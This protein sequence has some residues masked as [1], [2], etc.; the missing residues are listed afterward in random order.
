M[1]EKKYNAI[2]IAAVMLLGAFVSFLNSTFMNV[3]IPDIM[4]ELHITVSTAQ[5]LTNGYMLVLGIMIPFTAFL[6]DKFKTRTLFLAAMIIFSIG[7]LLGATA[8]SFPTLLTARL[9]QAAG[10][11]VLMPL[12]Q[13]VFLLIFPIEKRGL[14][15][16]VVG[17]IIAFAPAIGPTLSGWIVSHFPWRYL[18]YVTLPIALID[19]VLAIFILKNVTGGKK[20]GID[21]LSAITCVLGFG[22]L[23]LGFS[24]AGNSSWT[25]TK[26]CVPLII[27]IIALAIFTW[28]QFTMKTPMLQ[29]RVFKSKVFTLSTIIVMIVYAGFIASELIIPMYLQNGRGYSAFDA[30]LALLPGAVV[31]GVMN[32]ITGRLFDKVGARGL[33]LLGLILFTGGT[34]A[35][36]RLTPTTS[37]MYITIMYAVRL[38]GLSMFLMPLT[39]LGLNTLEKKYY[40]HGNAVNNTLRQIAGAIG[41][42]ILVTVMTKTAQSSGISNPLK[43]TIHGMNTSFFWA[44]VFGIVS[45][46]IAFIFVKKKQKNTSE[47]EGDLNPKVSK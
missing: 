46:V 29:L 34:F 13:T 19:I 12:V 9:L 16:G 44:G 17:L 5:W 21:I 41:T 33:S 1:A 30:G 43:A 42:S 8:H 28:R 36:T 37:Y 2:L 39:T 3:A 38:L 4:R 6:T 10:A 25:S 24:N 23:L 7:T 35:F 22:G 14:V 11:G 26:V 40:A 18:F 31:M 32:P 20:I 27:G 45:L 47:L 15:M